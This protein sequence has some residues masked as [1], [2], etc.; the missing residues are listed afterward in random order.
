MR[1]DVGSAWELHFA[2]AMGAL[3]RTVVVA[4]VMVGALGC[5]HGVDGSGIVRVP[6]DVRQLFSAE[7][8]GQVAVRVDWPEG[9]SA[10]STKAVGYLCAPGGAPATF[11]FTY[12][13]FDCAQKVPL[14]VHAWAAPVSRPVPLERCGQLDRADASDQP[15]DAE[16]AVASANGEVLVEVSDSFGK[17]DDGS[18]HFDLSLTPDR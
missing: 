5:E 13:G 4:I 9:S 2:G 15:T 12:F 10:S 7:K 6:E 16:E 17:C 14:T 18:F 8:P 11:Q 1:G 3:G